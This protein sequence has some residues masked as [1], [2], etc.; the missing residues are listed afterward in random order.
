MLRVVYCI[1]SNDKNE[2]IFGVLV[3][4]AHPG[5]CV[6]IG[7]IAPLQLLLARLCQHTRREK[8]K[9]I[10]LKKFCMIIIYTCY[11]LIAIYLSLLST[12]NVF[13]F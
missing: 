7:N 11:L 1:H 3:R 6:G 13:L 8:G 9:I 10:N 5:Y 2:E 12:T 4:I